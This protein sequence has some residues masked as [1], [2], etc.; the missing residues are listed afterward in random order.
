MATRECKEGHK[1]P[2]TET[3]QS[4]E[5]SPSVF[6][7]TG[8]Y[9]VVQ[10]IDVALLFSRFSNTI[11]EREREKDRNERKRK[12][13]WGRRWEKGRKKKR[14]RTKEDTTA[15]DITGRRTLC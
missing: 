13:E 2:S 8:V 15:T 12:P 14:N 9:S 1:Y 5:L 3:L 7:A 6:A 11:R 4:G 10:T